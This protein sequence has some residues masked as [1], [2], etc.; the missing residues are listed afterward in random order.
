MTT[1]KDLA[2][3]ISWESLRVNRCVD[4]SGAS[5]ACHQS[6]LWLR[7]H[8]LLQSAEGCVYLLRSG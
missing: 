2:W 6:A 5:T 8:G 7:M 1:G 4:R 3:V